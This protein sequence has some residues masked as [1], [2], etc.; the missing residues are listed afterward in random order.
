MSVLADELAKLRFILRTFGELTTGR[1]LE[2]PIRTISSSDL[3]LY[4]GLLATTAAALGKAVAWVLDQYQKILDIRIK[5]AEL[6]KKDGVPASELKGLKN[7]ANSRMETRI[8]EIVVEIEKTFSVEKDQGR[9]N[10]L[11]TG[12][13]FS[14]NMIATRV[15]KG[16]HFDIRIEP[17]NDVGQEDPALEKAVVTIKE[18]SPMLRHVS[19][20]GDP[21]LS[22]PEPPPESKPRIQKRRA[23]KVSKRVTTISKADNTPPE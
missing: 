6:Q 12:L 14:L 8:N 15:D 23:I 1:K 11:H 4:V 18:I 5:L 13:K 22:L 7:Y 21:I 16:Y 20:A 17:P 2:F 19:F 9:A 3:L 10:E